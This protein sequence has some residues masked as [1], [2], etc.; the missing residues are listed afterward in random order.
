M[1]LSNTILGA[2][3]A[4]VLAGCASIPE[5][6][7]V[8][9]MPGPG[10]PFDQFNADNAICMEFARQQIGV[11]PNDVAREQVVTGAAAG[12]A[13]GAASGALMGHGHEGQTESM[14]GAGLIVGSA[15]GANAANQSN[16]TLQRR[17][18]IAY[19]QCM[20]AKGNQ[21]PGYAP[22][23]YTPPPPPSH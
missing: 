19:Q 23:R 8:A 11:N 15:A 5:G 10:K 2:S 3:L 22:P 9:V 21:I 6:P 14:A 7:S 4:V 12:A 13:L 17:Y 16:M 20:Y 1:N 18:D